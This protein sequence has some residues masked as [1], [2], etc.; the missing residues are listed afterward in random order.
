MFIKESIKMIK[1]DKSKNIDI[2]IEKP[3]QNKTERRSFLKKA[4]YAAPTLIT[5]GYLARPKNANARDTGG[6]S[7]PDTGAWGN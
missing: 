4:V 2:S 3:V 6:E 1:N 5:M 7:A